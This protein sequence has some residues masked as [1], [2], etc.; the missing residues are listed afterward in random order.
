M[1]SS[2]LTSRFGGLVLLYASRL[3]G[4]MVAVVFMPLYARLLGPQEFGLAALV[5]SVQ[6][7]M[8]MLDLG[9]AG[10]LT[11]DLAQDPARLR[12]RWRDAERLLS[13]Y[14]LGLGAPLLLLAW[15]LQ[16]PIAIALA[17]LGLFWAHTLQNLSQ[18]CLIATSAVQRAALLQSGG[19]LLRA[20]LTVGALTAWESS[21]RAFVFSQLLGAVLHWAVSRTWGIAAQAQ[22]VGTVPGD[23]LVSRASLLDLARRGVPLFL[24]GIAGAAVLQVDKLLVGSLLGA[25]DLA[26]YFLATTFSLTPI[27]LLAGPVAQFFQ[28]RLIGALQ[29]GGA[30]ALAVPLRHL[31]LAILLTVALPTCLLW[32]VREPLIHLWLRDPRLMQPVADLVAILLPA[33][34]LGAIGNI[35][36]ALLVA[37]GDF[38]FQ[39]R[40]SALLTV[41]TLLAVATAGHLG[42]LAA[43][44]WIYLVYYALVTTGLWWRATCFEATAALARRSA[45]LAALALMTCIPPL[46]LWTLR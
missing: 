3:A 6:A 34:A 19:V 41:F 8:V 37:L 28:P 12:A 30:S 9:M 22:R 1:R 17:A 24:V 16:Q 11:R 7:L 36:L 18:A 40:F 13:V 29:Q 31:T 42:S 14:F 35:P 4:L 10:L 39:A 26:A 15:W 25:S 23:G 32:V 46:A 27:S 2:R 33:A 43:V 44:C 45:T 5:L 20:L 38:S 21:L